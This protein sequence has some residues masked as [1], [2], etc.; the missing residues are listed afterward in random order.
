MA[1]THYAW[2]PIKGGTAEK[3][4]NIAR[5]AKVTKSDLGVSD[6]DW[7]AMVQ[8][9]AIRT[10]KHPAPEDYEGSAVDYLRER[11]QEAQEMSGVDEEEAASELADVSTPPPP[12]PAAEPEP[13]K[14]SGSGDK[15]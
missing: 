12:A 7:D 10:K 3:P 8:A 6:A 4:V 13:E 9:G 1:E 11:L 2:T 15:K 5:G 14:A